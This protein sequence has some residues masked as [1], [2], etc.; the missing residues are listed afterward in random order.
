MPL[1]GG[2][3]AYTQQENPN[4]KNDLELW[5]R[6]WN[7]VW[8][9]PYNCHFA[10]TDAHTTITNSKKPKKKQSNRRGLGMR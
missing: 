5:Y 6:Q 3:I 10:V 9:F 8:V 4:A 7:V 2:G 1:G